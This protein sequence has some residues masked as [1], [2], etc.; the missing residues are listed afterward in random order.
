MANERLKPYLT[1]TKLNEDG[2]K[3]HSTRRI[4]RAKPQ[5][6]PSDLTPETMSQSLRG[7]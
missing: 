2:G 3:S 5:S 1:Q 4:I 6:N 7:V